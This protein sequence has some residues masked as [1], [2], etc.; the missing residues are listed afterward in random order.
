MGFLENF[1]SKVKTF[2]LGFRLNKIR[3]FNQA[4]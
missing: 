4:D 3:A 2:N 1:L